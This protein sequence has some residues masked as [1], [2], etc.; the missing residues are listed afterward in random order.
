MIN[1][2]EINC[3]RCPTNIWKYRRMVV[4]GSGPPNADIMFVGEAPREME[5]RAGKPFVGPAGKILNRLMNEA[6]I[7]RNEVYITNIVKCRPTN[8]G[9]TNRA[10]NLD[11]VKTCSDYLLAEIEKVDP[12]VI[13]PLGRTAT[14][15]FIPNSSISSVRGKEFEWRGRSIWKARTIIPQYHP[16]MALYNKNMFDV[17]IEDMKVIGEYNREQES[18]NLIYKNH[19]DFY[20]EVG[21]EKCL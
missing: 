18:I 21:K 12:K 15:F 4:M 1:G 10:P 9:V 8:S 3:R 17:L 20:K 6:G 14:N 11:E 2:I 19:K 5:D 16:A 7:D 13:S